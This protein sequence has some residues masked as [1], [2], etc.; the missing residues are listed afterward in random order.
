MR[1]SLLS[2]AVAAGLACASAHAGTENFTTADAPLCTQAQ[3]DYHNWVN[4][5]T[6]GTNMYDP[7]GD[8][9]GFNEAD[10]GFFMIKSWQ[11]VSGGKETF[12]G[13]VD[14]TQYY[15][16]E[17]I[18]EIFAGDE[19]DQNIY[20]V[21]RDT[22]NMG[23][24]ITGAINAGVVTDTDDIHNCSGIYSPARRC[25][26]A[27]IEWPSAYNSNPWFPAT[28]EGAYTSPVRG[29]FLCAYGPWVG[30]NAHGG[31]PEVHP[32][33]GLWWRSDPS[34]TG[35]IEQRRIIVA[36]DAS[37][38]YDRP[39]DFDP[40]NSE[41]KVWAGIPSLE[42]IVVPFILHASNPTNHQFHHIYEPRSVNVTSWTVFPPMVDSSDGASHTLSFNGTPRLTV[43]EHQ[44]DRNLGVHMGAWGST[45]TLHKMCR[46]SNGNVQGFYT[47]RTRVGSVTEEPTTIC[48]RGGCQTVMRTVR[49][50][51]VQEL[52]INRTWT[53]S[54][55]GAGDASRVTD[56]IGNAKS[57]PVVRGEIDWSS[58]RLV[59]DGGHMRLLGDV[60][61]ELR[62]GE[63]LASVTDEHGKALAQVDE[64]R[65]PKSSEAAHVVRVRDVDFASEKAPTLQ[66]ASGVSLGGRMVGLTVLPNLDVQPQAHESE[67][68]ED[69]L[70]QAWRELA[71]SVGME[72]GKRPASF[73]YLPN[74]QAQALPLFAPLK[75]GKPYAED[76][77]AV[78]LRLNRAAQ[79]G[80]SSPVT[81][82]QAIR[83]LSWTA[84]PG[85][86]LDDSADTRSWER[87]ARFS[88]PARYVAAT[89]TLSLDEVFGARRTETLDVYSHALVGES[90]SLAGE[91][92][93]LAA[94][95]ARVSSDELE[96]IGGEGD[97]LTERFLARS[98]P[99][100]DLRHAI[101]RAAFDG[102]I[103]PE[104]LGRVMRL[105][106]R[107]A[108]D[109]VASTQEPAQ[110]Y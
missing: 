104:E 18:G 29:K 55:P 16:Y 60:L 94:L 2:I 92:R 8:W 99:L 5:S 10:M 20:I 75:N 88:D 71:T 83:Q 48:S 100:A 73:A 107:H 46:L 93:E 21:P 110:L 62:Q 28:N 50:P 52:M 6:S 38:R 1:H 63:K 108:S 53:P 103:S 42:Y 11:P 49:R 79:K 80:E 96:L 24:V 39:D 30:D 17:G 43:V 81:L 64:R 37:G 105:A 45:N 34:V 59:A 67:A 4:A 32:S 95:Q 22:G 12:C 51:G 23:A 27:E 41:D 70:N 61:V 47:L 56:V 102:R 19:H 78:S 87:A 106:R 82:E 86:A 72:V 97:D 89:I 14:H 98:S 13:A 35:V 76:E 101:A 7:E 65:V 15:V 84:S 58:A 69:A 44:P 40:E 26:E 36:G 54:D 68:T 66:F 109:S 57:R 3:I 74:W 85:I 33:E 90:T 9:I 91:L 77:S 31:R 25:F